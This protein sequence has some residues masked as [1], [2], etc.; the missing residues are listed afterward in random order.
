MPSF[1]QVISLSRGL[2]ILRAVNHEGRS[3]VGSL[4]RATGLD[5]PTIVRLLETLEQQ[6]YLFRRPGETYYEP[7]GKVRQ[8]SS[9]YSKHEEVGR[10]AT[11]VLNEF[12]D[13][14]GWPTNLAIYDGDAMVMAETIRPLRGMAVVR[15]P[16]YRFPLLRTSP[17]LAY[18][19]H[20]EEE[21]RREIL[22]RLASEPDPA[23]WNRPGC[24]EAELNEKLDLIR[25]QGYALADRDYI[26][27]VFDDNMWAMSVPINGECE[28]HGA[29]G[30]MVLSQVLDEEDGIPQL[31]D[32]I[33]RLAA[34][35]AEALEY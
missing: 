14:I 2:E 9:G 3:T 25:A 23:G 7:A 22:D 35:I 32:P 13:V 28:L 19:A 11:P 16:G 21:Q 33:R 34:R 1:K 30:V 15:Q 20:L 18:F 4:H 24:S 17:G 5:K 29:V 10:K 6:G 26:A 27:A 8:L 31:I 12:R